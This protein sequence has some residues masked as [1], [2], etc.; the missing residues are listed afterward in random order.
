MGLFTCLNRR[1]RHHMAPDSTANPHTHSNKPQIPSENPPPYHDWTSIPDT[2]LLPAPPSIA[3]KSSKNNATW[4]DAARAHAFCERSPPYTP[5]HPSPAALTAVRNSDIVL[6]RPPEY[7]GD[8]KPI[9]GEGP[10][11]WSAKSRKGCGDCIFLSMTVSI[12]H[13]QNPCNSLVIL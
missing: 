13:R 12:H 10:G 5:V 6:E 7:L 11:L 4:E 9:S 8:L 2:S 1:R 3:H